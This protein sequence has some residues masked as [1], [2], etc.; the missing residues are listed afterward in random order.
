MARIWIIFSL[1]LVFYG[2][3]V[4]R[5]FYWQV[6]RSSQLRLEAASQYYVTFTLPAQR[7][8]ILA[9]DGKPLV[10]NQS[11]YLAYAEPRKI[12]DI[13]SFASQVSALLDLEKGDIQTSLSEPGRVWVPLA[14]KV[15]AA[16]VSELKDLKLAGLGFEKEPRRMYPESSMAAH[17]VGFV[18]S[19]ENGND[20]GYFGIEGYYD[21]ELGGKDGML[22]LEKDVRGQPILV[23]ETR[24][25]EPEDGR[26]LVLWLDRTVERIVE[27]R[28]LEGIATYGAK[29]GSVVVMDPKTGGIVAMAGV[30]SYDPGTFSLFDKDAY[31]NPLVA[32]TYEPGSTF[33]VLVMAMGVDRNVV[34]PT[35]MAEETGPVRVGEYFIR[36]WDDKYRGM[37]SMT[38]VL[39]H[40]SNVGMVSV[41]KKLGREGM[42]RVIAGFG[43]GQS[44]GIDLQEEASS[45]V[46]EDDAWGEIDLATASFGQGIAVS[47]I[48]MVR[49]V[50]AIAN[51]GELVEPRV[52][53]EIRDGA[54][55]VVPI[56]PKKARSVI[57]P[58]SARVLTEMMIAAVDR[59]EAKWA[60]PKGYRIA[61][62]TGTA[63]IP[64][65]GHYDDKKTIASFVGFAPADDPKFVML[66]T[67]REPTSSPWGSETAAP[68]FFTIAK[69]LFSYYGIAP[70]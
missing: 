43:F 26:S 62:K 20:Q 61:G 59:G 23:G 8:A 30:P 55:K 58:A 37:I 2:L 39:V 38:D 48:Q 44:T 68:L 4:V 14:H 29:E 18:G 6:M 5:L 51:G 69:D 56:K 11:A 16:R 50:A 47:P 3:L 1:I 12:T 45:S 31:K 33:K 10:L 70:Q 57:S 65:A 32:G 9:S 19:D 53:K 49:A 66:V 46:R 28:L 21:R 64:V 63:Q 24:R 67:L 25:I 13:P 36:T 60:K 42:L 52:V 34:T 40:S 22:Q 15:E 41:A 17:L 35:M 27:N 54:G 7:G